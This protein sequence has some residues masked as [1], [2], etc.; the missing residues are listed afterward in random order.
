[1]LYI[2]G[3]LIKRQ[4]TSKKSYYGIV[5]KVEAIDQFTTLLLVLSGDS[6]MVHRVHCPK[7]YDDSSK[8]I[9]AV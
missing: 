6:G 4:I 3:D 7:E 1:M 5:I 2:K 9:Q 8:L